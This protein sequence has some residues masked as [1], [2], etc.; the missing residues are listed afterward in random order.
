MTGLIPNLVSTIIPVHNRPS[1]VKS[2][3]ESVLNQTYRPIEIILVDDGST[4]ETSVVCKDLVRQHPEIIHFEAQPNLGPGPAREKGR[5]IAQGEF[6]QYLDSDDVLFPNKFADQ[7]KVLKENPLCEVAYGIT[8]LVDLEG[9][10]LADP[11]KWTGR[12]ETELFP[13]LLVDRWWCT[14]T[15]L[16]RRSVCDVVGAWTDLKF[17]QDWEYDARVGA[18]RVKLISS[19]TLVSEHRTHEAVRQTGHGKWLKPADQVRFFFSLYESAIG[20]GVKDTM[21]EMQHFSR[22]VFSQAR[23]CGAAGDSDSAQKL[24]ELSEKS[25]AVPGFSMKFIGVTSKLIGWNLTGK[26]CELRDT[27]AKKDAGPLTRKQSWMDA[28]S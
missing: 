7:V 8:R 20:A 19:N 16:Y 25:A 17:S 10:I 21:P 26:V 23:K 6:I 22:W 24:F 28:E 11:F 14:H 12:N 18:K 27:L 5:G 13:G 4:D 2:A 15:P 1:M 3:V 9:N